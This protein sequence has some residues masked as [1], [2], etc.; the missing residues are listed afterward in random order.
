[1]RTH[2]RRTVPLGELIVTAFDMAAEHSTD[3]LEVSRVATH[4]VGRMLRLLGRAAR[5]AI[6]RFAATKPPRGTR[7]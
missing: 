7:H 3:S 6:T 2:I 4:T 5:P 1:M